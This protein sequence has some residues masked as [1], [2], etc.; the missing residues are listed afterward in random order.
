MSTALVLGGAACVW[1]DIEAALD[2]GEFD[3]VVACNDVAAA[4]PGELDGMVSLHGDKLGLWSERRA[5]AGHPP[6]RRI[7]AHD[8]AR[9]G[10]RAMPACVTDYVPYV[11]PGQRETGS[12]GLFA[13]KVAL[14]DLGFDKAVVC[15]APMIDLPHFFDEVVWTAAPN[16]RRGWIEAMPQIAGRA[17]S[18]SGWTS[19]RLGRPTEE[20]LA[21]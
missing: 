12:S 4:W 6:A 14:I 13:L 3:G 7:F 18:M 16:H 15:G 2:L 5:R 21:A 9:S 17:R 1:R 11:F 20:W 10:V 8:V 19:E